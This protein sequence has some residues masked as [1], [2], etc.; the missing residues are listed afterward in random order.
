ME[1]IELLNNLGD[2]KFRDKFSKD[3]AFFTLH[4]ITY[5]HNPKDEMCCG[6]N[7]PC[8]TIQAIIEQVS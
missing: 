8:P 2:P 3:A 6:T 5:L 4:V 1:R 7:Y